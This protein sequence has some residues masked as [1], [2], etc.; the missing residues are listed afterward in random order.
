MFS[1]NKVNSPLGSSF[2]EPVFNNQRRIK[3]LE[4]NYLKYISHHLE[5]DT[6]NQWITRC[7]GQ[8][9]KGLLKISRVKTSQG[10]GNN[11]S[12]TL[13]RI[14]NINQKKKIS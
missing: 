9:K 4:M 11:I 14:E 5:T 1:P 10:K 7:Q 8:N 12:Q 6:I 2:D 3:K 13:K